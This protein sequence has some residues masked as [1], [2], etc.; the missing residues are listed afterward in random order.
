[1]RVSFPSPSARG[2]AGDE[3]V[4][5]LAARLE[6]GHHGA[7]VVLEEHHRAQDDVGALDVGVGA[8]DRRPRRP[9]SRVAQWTLNV[10]PGS[11][12]ARGVLRARAIGPGEVVVEGDGW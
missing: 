10:S 3:R 12:R 7:D 4:A 5:A 6:G 8:P 11:S 1:M 9:P 2:H